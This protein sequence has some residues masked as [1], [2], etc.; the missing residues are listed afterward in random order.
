MLFGATVAMFGGGSDSNSYTPVSAEVEAYEP[1]IQKYALILKIKIFGIL[2]IYKIR[3]S[4]G[5]I[6]GR[7]FGKRKQY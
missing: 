3:V 2:P 7:I 5:K 4:G 6:Y 1:I